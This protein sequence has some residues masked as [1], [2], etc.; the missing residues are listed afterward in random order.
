M[1]IQKTLL[2]GLAIVGG[3][4]AIM[5]ITKGMRK[6]SAMASGGAVTPTPVGGAPVAAPSIP[7]V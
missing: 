6:G 5:Y 1:K 4:V 3:I 2:Y 7:A